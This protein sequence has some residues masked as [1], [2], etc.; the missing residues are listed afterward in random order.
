MDKKEK[1]DDKKV[2]REKEEQVLKDLNINRE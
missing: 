2:M 1:E